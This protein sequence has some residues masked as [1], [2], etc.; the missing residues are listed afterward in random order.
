[1][2][3]CGVSLH[4]YHSVLV[5]RFKSIIQ[6]HVHHWSQEDR[7]EARSDTVCSGVQMALVLSRDNS[8]LDFCKESSHEPVIKYFFH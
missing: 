6:Y 8:Q 3:L 2:S 4:H 7:G 1:M 5:F